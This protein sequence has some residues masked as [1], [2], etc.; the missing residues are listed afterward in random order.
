[1]KEKN[2]KYTK[3]NRKGNMV[4]THCRK[5][6]NKL[7]LPEEMKKELHNQCNQDNN[8]IYMM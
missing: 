3:N 4:A 2:P 1:M 8:N 7:Y 6:G 5:C